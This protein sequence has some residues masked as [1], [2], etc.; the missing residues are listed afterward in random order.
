MSERTVEVK[1][2]FV[3]P[4]HNYYGRHGKG[5]ESHEIVDRDEIELVAGRGVT[6]DR[7]FDYKQDYK[8]QVTLFDDA[9]VSAVRQV[10]DL[11][12]LSAAA[13]RRNVVTNGVELNDLI[14]K[15]FD[16]GGVVLSGSEEARPCYWMDE[17]CAPGVEGFLKG[18][19][20]L[21]CRIVRGGVLRKGEMTLKTR[22]NDDL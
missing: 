20:G 3:S 21:R 8:G 9:T 17:A 11:P 16:L 1:H 6:G 19:G 13:F 22:N 4:G 10:F 14:G 5:S 18:R 7:F 2:L 12:E 15:T